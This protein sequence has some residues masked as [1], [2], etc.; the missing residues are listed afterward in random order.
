MNTTGKRTRPVDLF[1]PLPA[2]HPLFKRGFVIGMQRSGNSLTSGAT[3]PPAP[4]PSAKPAELSQ[5]PPNQEPPEEPMSDE[6]LEKLAEEAKAFLER[7]RR[8]QRS[9]KSKAA[10]TP[11]NRS[12]PGADPK[13]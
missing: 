12:A 1:P 2:D 11:A 7:K 3:P 8:Q 4:K 9:S 6:Q 13:S 5:E 10:P